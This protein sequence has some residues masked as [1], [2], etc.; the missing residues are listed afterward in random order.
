MSN[1]RQ[2]APILGSAKS[3]AK[4]LQIAIG[5]CDVVRR[6]RDMTVASLSDFSIDAVST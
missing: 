5:R 4:M 3:A 1:D 6:S 2:Q